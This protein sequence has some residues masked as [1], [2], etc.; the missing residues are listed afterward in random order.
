MSLGDPEAWVCPTCGRL[1]IGVHDCAVYIGQTR[2]SWSLPSRPTVDPELAFRAKLADRCSFC[3]GPY[4]ETT[5]HAYSAT[6]RACGPC[7]RE[8][9]VFYRGRL[10]NPLTLALMR[11]Y[12]AIRFRRKPRRSN[13]PA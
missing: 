13:A 10:K 12:D 7:Y 6:F 3:L 2:P 5:G 4:H 9:L 1:V 8:W 11:M